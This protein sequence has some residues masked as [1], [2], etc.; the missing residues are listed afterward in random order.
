[1]VIK[2]QMKNPKEKKKTSKKHKVKREKKPETRGTTFTESPGMMEIVSVWWLRRRITRPASLISMC[3]LTPGVPY[4]VSGW[5]PSDAPL[6][7][8][9][10]TATFGSSAL[11]GIAYT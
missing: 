7:A 1:M 4:S 3:V 2:Q 10:A 9:L 6:N 8:S 5:P 11:A